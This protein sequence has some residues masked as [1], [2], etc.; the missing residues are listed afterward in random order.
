MTGYSLMT[1]SVC[2]QKFVIQIVLHENDVVFLN[3]YSD[4]QIQFRFIN[5]SNV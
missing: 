4:L 3:V 2:I 5:N 1:I